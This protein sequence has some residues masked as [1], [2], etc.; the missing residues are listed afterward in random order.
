MPFTEAPIAKLRIRTGALCGA[1]LGAFMPVT[2]LALPGYTGLIN[3]YCQEQGAPRVRYTDD[4]CTLCHHPGTFTSDPAHRVEPVWTEFELGRASGDYGF[5]CPLQGDTGPAIT[6][7]DLAVPPAVDLPAPSQGGPLSHADMPWMS[8]GYPTGHTTVEALAPADQPG[9]AQTSLSASPVAPSPARKAA[10]A[11]ES[12]EA[13]RKLDKLRDDIGITGAQ[14]AVW[15]ELQEAVLAAR[16]GSAPAPATAATPT[17][18]EQLDNQQRHHALRIARLRA[19]NT[20]LVRVNGQLNDRQ[21]RLLAAR[22]SLL[23]AEP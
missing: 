11:A 4:G 7:A 22:L 20:A 18:S 13:K 5:F 9:P 16:A 12:D 2:A 15:Q 19:V 6:S 21:Q 23:L 3:S 8:L 17:V 14:Q 10:T 1:L